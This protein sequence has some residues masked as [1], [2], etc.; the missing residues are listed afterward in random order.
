MGKQPFDS[1]E[2]LNCHKRVISLQLDL[3]DNGL[4][5]NG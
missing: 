2:E 3:R 4:E 1:Q 5:T